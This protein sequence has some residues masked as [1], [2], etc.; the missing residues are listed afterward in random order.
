VQVRPE[1]PTVRPPAVAGL[2]YPADPARLRA[3]VSELL[4]KA[5]PAA[6]A[7]LRPKAL[8]A[9]HA[10]YAYSGAVAATAFAALGEGAARPAGAW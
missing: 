3:E 8:V 1:G 5:E 10:G 4:A 2:F 7:G 9:P 6:P